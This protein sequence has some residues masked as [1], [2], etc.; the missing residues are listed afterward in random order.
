MMTKE[1][2]QNKTDEELLEMIEQAKGH[3]GPDFKDYYGC[4]FSYSFLTDTL[5]RRG[6]ALGWHR[7]SADSPK[8]A[9][10]AMEKMVVALK[11]VECTERK[12]FTVPQDTAR[13]WSTFAAGMPYKVPLID[14]AL[15]MFMRA[16]QEGKVEFAI[17]QGW[18]SI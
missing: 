4:D 5:K 15:K 16:C 8:N 3:T 6:W 11:K 9:G 1:D 18:K 14:A 7:V 17:N 10:V 2:L 12:V 13:E